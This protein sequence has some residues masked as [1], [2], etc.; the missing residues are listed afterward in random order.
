[1]ATKKTFL[2]SILL[3]LSLCSTTL[4]AETDKLVYPTK[5]NP[6]FTLQVPTDWKLVQ[7]EG[8]GDYFHLHGPTGA[9]FSF[10]TIKG[11]QSTL[12][13]TMKDRLSEV[14]KKYSDVDFDPA[15]DW[16]PHGLTGFYAVGDA[17]ESD[18]NKVRI[19]MGWCDL[20]NGKIAEL[21]FI[22]DVTDSEGKTDA[23]NIMDSLEAP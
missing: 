2:L 5:D 21:W 22:T 12:D 10:R 14:R 19:A 17:K 18:G 7:A 11:N 9:V 16:S 3:G 8:E 20:K 15:K 23:S 1:M 4:P 13:Q 6:E